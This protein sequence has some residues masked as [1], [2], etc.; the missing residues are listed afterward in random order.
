MKPKIDAPSRVLGGSAKD[1][2]AR[3]KSDKGSLNVTPPLD[4]KVAKSHQGGA[5]KELCSD[6]ECRV[7]KFTPEK[8]DKPTPHKF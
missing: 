8:V 3:G 2:C 5:V 6:G 4:S 7:T 1:A